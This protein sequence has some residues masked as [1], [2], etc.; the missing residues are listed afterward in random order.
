MGDS[1][2]RRVHTIASHFDAAGTD[3]LPLLYAGRGGGSG[4][5]AAP[6]SADTRV[7]SELQ[8]LLDHDCATER[9]A[10][11]RLMAD[12]LFTPRWNISVDKERELAL[13]RL[14]ALCH[15]GN[16]SIT[17][18]RTNPLRIFAAHE[19]ATLADVSM[20]TKMTVQ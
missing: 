6:T 5:G 15:S 14:R 8:A 7:A 10:M 4:L 11:K 19:C 20:A 2:H 9:A 3:S 12:P 17:D 13:Q 18:F 1:A 16:F